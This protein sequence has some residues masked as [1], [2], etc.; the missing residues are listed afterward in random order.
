MWASLR[1]RIAL[2]ATG[3]T[4]VVL[5]LVAALL[6]QNQQRTLDAAVDAAL[7]SEIDNLQRDLAI[8]FGRGSRRQ[9]PQVVSLEQLRRFAQSS[10]N[11]FQWI[12]ED[13]AVIL[14]VGGF[15]TQ[16]PILTGDRLQDDS[17]TYL[18]ISDLENKRFR[19]VSSP[20]GE[21]TLVVGY[22]LADVDEAQRSLTRTLMFTLPALALLLGLLIWFFVGRA[23]APV[24]RMRRE[25]DGISAQ[26]LDWRVSTPRTT[27]LSSL[28]STMNRMLG[29]IQDSLTKQQRFVSDASHELR[30]PLTGIRGQLEVNIAHPDAPGREESE[31]E[32]L[33]ETIRMQSLVEDLLALARSDHGHQHVPMGLVDLD[34]VVNDEVRRQR[35][36]SDKTINARLEPVQ[37][38]G[39]SDQLTRV[40]RNL[41]DNANRHAVAAIEVNVVDRGGIA[42]LHVSDDGP[43]VPENM[44][45]GIFERFTR[46]DEAR[47]RDSGGSGLGLSICQTIVD[48]HGGSIALEPPSRF[49]VELPVP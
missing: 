20:V 3:V 43:G 13:G 45:S 21:G 34:D 40:V 26:D 46:S 2:V 39:N 44:R 47:D 22:S 14:G 6:V 27:E 48:A 8:N 31:R 15:N 16:I 7:A 4:F 23:L 30:S 25:V 32:M 36:S 17:G 11:N 9:R 38:V 35:R 29:R 37:V 18:T 24:E 28:A 33:E 5:V 49:V 12:G 10:N 42:H 1:N 19:V 41:I